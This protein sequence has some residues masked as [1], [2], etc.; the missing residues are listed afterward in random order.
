MCVSLSPLWFATEVFE[1]LEAAP[2]SS[3]RGRVFY[4]F[5]SQ[6]TSHLVFEKERLTTKK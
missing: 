3:V 6:S 2:A 1:I 4:N 5:S